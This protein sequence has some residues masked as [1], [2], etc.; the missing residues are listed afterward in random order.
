[1]NDCPCCSAQLLRHARHNS[2]YWLCTRCRQEMPV[3]PRLSANSSK[4]LQLDKSL[5]PIF[6]QKIS[7]ATH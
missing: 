1:M 4:N 2:I 3:L 6:P 7:L 5:H